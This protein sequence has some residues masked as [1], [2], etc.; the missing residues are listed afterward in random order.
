M[1]KMTPQQFLKQVEQAYL[2]ARKPTMPG[3]GIFRHR[4]RSTSGVQEDL[5][6]Y[7]IRSQANDLQVY[8]DQPITIRPAKGVSTA[9]EQGGMELPA[10][11]KKTW[12]PDI[13]VVRRHAHSEVDDTVGTI[14]ALVDVKTDLGWNREDESFKRVCENLCSVRAG[15]QEGRH[16]TLPPALKRKVKPAPTLNFD[17]AK[18]RCAERLTCHV[19]VVTAANSGNIGEKESSRRSISNGMNV[20]LHV[21]MDL[22]PNVSKRELA[23]A[24]NLDGVGTRN[25][26]KFARNMLRIPDFDS[27]TAAILGT[28]R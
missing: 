8:V 22:H 15:L 6:A 4:V 27:L 1:V 5:V 25:A 23:K 17:G 2:D 7:F 19:V 24:A 21:L 10:P 14:I 12:Y 9:P 26:G 11:K 3:E 18:M 16:R 28:T 20:Q 13:I